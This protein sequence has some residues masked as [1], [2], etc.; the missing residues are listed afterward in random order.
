[1][2]Y[3]IIPDKEALG[4][5]AWCQGTIDEFAEVFAVGAK[6]KPDA[7]L[8]AFESHCIQIEL[9]SEDK[10]VCMMVTARNSEAKNNGNDGMFLLCSESCGEALKAILEKEVES[11]MLF[12]T[13]RDDL[14]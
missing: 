10:S 8:S 1:M 3:D 12:D 6:L 13:V 7:D 11:G 14:A 2:D 4:K 9:V 5:C